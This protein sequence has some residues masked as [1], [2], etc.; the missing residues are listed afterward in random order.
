MTTQELFSFRLLLLP[1]PKYWLNLSIND[2]DGEYWK[3]IPEYEGLYQ[4]SNLGRIKSLARE[5]RK[6]CN[7]IRDRIYRQNSNRGDYLSITLWK[8]Q[9]RSET[10]SVHILMGRSFIPN[11]LKKPQINHKDCIK[12]NNWLL[13]LE[14]NTRQ[15]NGKH[16]F[17]MGRFPSQKGEKHYGSKLKNDQVLEIF[18]SKAPNKEL[19]KIF[20]VNR[21]TIHDIKTGR[22]W[23]HLTKN[24]NNG[25]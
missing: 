18:K 11:P 13:N 8:N 23:S 15:E 12:Y 3:N 17:L 9:K 6:G 2:I 24:I 10:T 1:S 5:R 22:K 14:W 7:V 20:G 19:A 21:I 4:I 16:A 25:K